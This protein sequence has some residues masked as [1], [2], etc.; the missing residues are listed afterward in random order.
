MSVAVK[1]TSNQL[2]AAHLEAVGASPKDIAQRLRFSLSWVS[3]LREIPEYCLAVEDIRKRI[4]EEMAESAVDLAERFD[5]EAGSAFDTIVELHSSN[6][7]QAGVRLSAAKTIL[8]RA[9]S[10]PKERKEHHVEGGVSIYIGSRRMADITEALED[11]GETKM[12]EFIDA[13]FEE[14]AEEEADDGEIV[15]SPLEELEHD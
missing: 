8:D 2:L 11:V 13:E 5:K 15:A 1:L 4:S 10:A 12:I 6:L 7:T 3:R 9:P 14:V